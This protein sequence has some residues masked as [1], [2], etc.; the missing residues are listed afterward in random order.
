MQI[1]GP[2]Q[3]H[4]AHAINA[5][6]FSGRTAGTQ[7][8]S[9]SQAVDRVE[10][11]PAA[12]AAANAAEVGGIRQDLVNTIR[13]QIAAGTYDTPDKMNLAMERLLDQIG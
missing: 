1:N 5:P 9:A 10:I 12:Q 13:S 6:H 2:S 8:T 4:G 11:S 3:V 7:A